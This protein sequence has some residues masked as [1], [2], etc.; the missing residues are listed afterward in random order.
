VQDNAAALWWTPGGKP[1]TNSSAN[2]DVEQF[3]SEARSA[4][5]GAAVATFVPPPI[6]SHTL[7]TLHPQSLIINHQ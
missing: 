2:S 4:G 5:A 3:W 1:S 7:I 6:Q